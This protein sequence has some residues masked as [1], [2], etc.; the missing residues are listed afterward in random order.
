MAKTKR[1]N[2]VTEEEPSKAE[3]LRQCFNNTLKG[4]RYRTREHT[5][6]HVVKTS[7]ERW[8]PGLRGTSP[9]A[10]LGG[11]VFVFTDTWVPSAN[12]RQLIHSSYS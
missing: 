7:R 6:T 11:G 10:G 12:E 1:V 4:E 2:K 3:L 5:G 8:L 9:S